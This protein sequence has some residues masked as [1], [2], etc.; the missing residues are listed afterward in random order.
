MDNLASTRKAD[1]AF[2][3]SLAWSCRGDGHEICTQK[4]ERAGTFSLAAGCRRC[5][6]RGYRSIAERAS[7]RSHSDPATSAVAIEDPPA[8]CCISPLTLQD[9]VQNLGATTYQDVYG[10]MTVSPTTQETDVPS[11]ITIY[12]VAAAADTAQ[13]LSDI[14]SAAAAASNATSYSTVDVAHT[15]AQ[16]NALTMTIA[17]SRDTWNNQG[18]DLVMWGPDPSSNKVI[19]TL[20][21]YTPT[22]AQA[23]YAAYGTSWISVST[24][25]MDM[26]FHLDQGRLADVPPFYGGD[27]IYN[28]E[29]GTNCTDGF[30]M[31]GATHPQNHWQM[32]A[33]HCPNQ[34]WFTNLDTETLL[35][36]TATNYWA[37]NGGSTNFDV[38]TI[39]TVNAVGTVWGNGDTSY[40]PYTI[41]TRPQ[42]SR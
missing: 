23:L 9:T 32:T 3:G 4:P 7:A 38:Q 30:T 5:G 42:A 41:L 29:S 37:P 34:T 6:D 12:I 40:S 14:Q 8:C 22:A 2:A 17:S 1:V 10:G 36:N 25:P 35:G 18:V 13:F 15:W 27:I 28:N 11:H 19:I 20:E 33:G 31:I 26:T 21:S 39:G 16:L 24:Q